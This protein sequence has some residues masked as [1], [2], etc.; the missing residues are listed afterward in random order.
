[1]SIMYR[2]ETVWLEGNPDGEGRFSDVS[3]GETE[4]QASRRGFAFVP[5]GADLLYQKV[6]AHE[7]ACG[8]LLEDIG[9]LVS[10]EGP[11]VRKGY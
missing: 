9:S 3:W 7:A 10:D 6:Q 4:G 5:V 11:L 2:A 8:A 1:M